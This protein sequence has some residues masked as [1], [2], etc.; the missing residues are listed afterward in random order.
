M[1]KVLSAVAAVSL[2]VPGLAL[3]STW[4]I[5]SS[6]S[7]ATFKVRHAMVSDVRGEFGKV[8]GVVNLDDKDVT[9]STVEATIDAST[10]NTRD[11]K[12]DGHLK[13]PDFFDVANHPTI[14]FKSKKVAKAGKDKLKVTGDLTMRGVTKEVVLDVV[15][16]GNEAKDPWGNVKRGATATTKLNRK[17]FGLQWNK[18]LETGGLLVGEEVAVQLDIELNKKSDETA[19]K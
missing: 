17:D 2:F 14:T 6:H 15:T 11:E 7:S 12:R 19:A 10:I 3:A 4:D 8:A 9:K 16:S 18:A 13:S 1:K 5:D